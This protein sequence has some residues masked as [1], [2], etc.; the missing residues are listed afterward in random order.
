[1]IV[2]GRSAVPLF[3]PMMAIA[4]EDTVADIVG[5]A[6]RG[7]K[8]S[9]HE[10]A[11]KSGLKM[12]QLRAVR[13]GQIE[14]SVIRALAPVLKLDAQAL[15]DLAAGNSEPSALSLE[16]LAQFNTPY[17]DMRVNG[18]LVWDPSTRAA[19]A[20]DTGAD[21]SEMLQCVR[22]EELS[23]KMILLTHAHPDHI[24]DLDR[25]RRE[26]RGKSVRYYLLFLCIYIN[27]DNCH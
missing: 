3:I 17:G 7:W 14:E 23:V 13:E 1:M 12:E 24:E 11:Q 16:G 15:L 26:I 25:L 10:L 6:Q 5:K 20:F 18:Y 19:A 2:S 9:D 27:R 21:C 8:I 4:L 22:K